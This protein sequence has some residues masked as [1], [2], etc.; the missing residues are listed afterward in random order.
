MNKLLHP[1]RAMLLLL[2]AAAS[3]RADAPPTADAPPANAPRL[4]DAPYSVVYY[5]LTPDAAQSDRQLDELQA[6]GC[7]E[8]LSLV[9]WWHA[10]TLGGDYW[11]KDYSPDQ[12]GEGFW[13][14]VDL[15]VDGCR[16]RGI[17]P[18]L[19]LGSFREFDGLFHP[20]DPSGAVEPYAKWVGQLVTRYRGKVDHYM[21]LDEENDKPCAKNNYDGSPE[22]YLSRIVIPLSTAIRAA[23][24]D[25]KISTCGVGAAPA[26][27]W[28]LRLID[29]G[30]PRYID[31]VACNFWYSMAEDRDDVV[32]L[33][34]AVRAKWPSARFY[35]NGVVYAVNRGLDDMRQAAC[36]A[37][38]MFTFFELGWDSAPLY[39]YQFSMTV[40]TK[41]NYGIGRFPTATDPG[42]RSAAWRA[43]QTIAHV[44]NDRQ[45][46]QPSEISLE[47]T[48]AATI[49]TA[50]HIQLR[51]VPPDVYQRVFVDD[52]KRLIVYLVYRDFRYPRS[53]NWNLK[54]ES[55]GWGNPRLIDPLD[56]TSLKPLDHKAATGAIEI[57]DLKISTLPTI[58]VLERK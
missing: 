37:Q 31:G 48:P 43:Y 45:R 2:I 47:L 10:D 16:A 30:L 13:K 40:D 17:R 57:E 28:L 55:A 14:A 44:F 34:H 39:L 52:G 53:G 24:P 21:L 1:T 22:Q 25:A 42:Q 50:N 18:A 41:E 54:I 49:E 51:V 29:L 8:A 12:I 6:L 9:Y 46:V 32:A 56:Y 4:S 5:S 58:I 23:D 26:T 15:F 3:A 19:R 27:D 35:S 20:M 33:M 38:S 36:V 11:K 7:S